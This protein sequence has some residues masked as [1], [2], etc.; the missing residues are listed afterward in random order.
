MVYE[1]EPEAEWATQEIK[2]TVAENIPELNTRS[3]TRGEI[4]TSRKVSNIEVPVYFA[5]DRNR[6]E[7][8]SRHLQ[9]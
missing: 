8:D 3:Q 1:P 4:V 7:T 5:T 2:I 6:K 9:K